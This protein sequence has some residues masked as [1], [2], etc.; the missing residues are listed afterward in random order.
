MIR[1]NRSALSNIAYKNV[2]IL[3]LLDILPYEFEKVFN[4]KMK[5]LSQ[6]NIEFQKDFIVHIS[7]VALDG[8]VNYVIYLPVLKPY[9]PNKH[10]DFRSYWIL[11]DCIHT[12]VK[13]NNDI[14]QLNN[15]MYELQDFAKEYDFSIIS[16]FYFIFKHNA[17][18]EWIEVKA[19][20]F[21][22]SK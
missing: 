2:I 7:Q 10:F 8:R 11:T 17:K 5:T 9:Q 1:L 16:P 12:R 3:E 15:A 6:L 21:D 20:V 19:K 22:E 18:T 13:G 14:S 4:E